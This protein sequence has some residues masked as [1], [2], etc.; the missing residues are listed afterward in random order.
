VFDFRRYHPEAEAA[1]AYVKARRGRV[2]VV[3]DPYLSPAA[4]HADR[5][6]VAGIAGP[7]LMDSYAAVV[8]L[9]DLFVSDLVERDP[10]RVRRRIERVDEARRLMGPGTAA[11]A[12]PPRSGGAP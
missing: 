11:H 12:R 7:R 8:A 1:A 6:L 2:L 3:T 9:I 5:T 4:Q 10:E